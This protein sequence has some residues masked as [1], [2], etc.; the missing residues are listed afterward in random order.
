MTHEP[1]ESVDLHGLADWVRATIASGAEA[2]VCEIDC[3]SAI[4]ALAVLEATLDPCE[5]DALLRLSRP[6]QRQRTAV[7]RGT[8]RHALTACLDLPAD[9][10]PL[11][12]DADGRPTLATAGDVAPWQASCAHSGPLGAFA[13][14]AA[15]PIGVDVEPIDGVRFADHIAEHML[16]RRE[17]ALYG[18]LPVQVRAAWLAR[19]WVC[20]EALLKAMGLGLRID[21]RTVEVMPGEWDG[22][23]QSGTFGI[24][25]QPAWG[26]C[27]WQ[28]CNA[29]TA[30][31]VQRAR[32]R[33]R[34][35]RLAF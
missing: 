26:G 7:V 17:M 34:R 2:I 6:V 3:D 15:H 23:C 14:A 4:P 21:P 10:V 18:T 19:A 11:W 33:V 31:A 30:V 16:H 12:R 27:V 28:R 8:L 9:R 24:H 25:A 32:P 22:E 29:V 35:V 5:R 20:K 1:C 13:I